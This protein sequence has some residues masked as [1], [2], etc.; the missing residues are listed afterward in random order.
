MVVVE[1]EEAFEGALTDEQLREVVPWLPHI[2]I[3]FPLAVVNWD[4]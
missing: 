1:E 4:T 3:T 2:L